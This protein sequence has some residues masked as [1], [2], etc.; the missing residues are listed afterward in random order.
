MTRRAAG[1]VHIVVKLGGS[2]LR[3]PSRLAAAVEVVN[4]LPRDAGLLIVPGGG[5]FADA[6][7]DA[8]R[9]LRFGDEAA[10]WM[11]VLAMDQVAHILAERLDRASIVETEDEIGRGIEAGRPVLAPYRLLRAADALPHAL[12]HTW[13]VTSD[14]I[15]AW[16]AG[17]LGADRLILVKPVAPTAAGLRGLVDPYFGIALP[18]GVTGSAV[19]LDELADAVRGDHASPPT[20]AHGAAHPHDVRLEGSGTR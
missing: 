16:F 4:A 2:F 10:H 7:R 15:A 20:V 17:R 11:A 9:A 13:D 12:P 8:D 18:A 6:V 14:S 19:T 3:D 5:P 1:S